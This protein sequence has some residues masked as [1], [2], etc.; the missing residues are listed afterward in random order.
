VAWLILLNSLPNR[1]PLHGGKLKN[2]FGL[3][4]VAFLMQSAYKVPHR[5][6]IARPCEA[7]LMLFKYSVLPDKEWKRETI[8]AIPP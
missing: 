7:L 1:A 2:L 8:R 4:K 3:K 6:R 5:L